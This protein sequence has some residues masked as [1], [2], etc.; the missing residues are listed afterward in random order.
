[1]PTCPKCH[2]ADSIFYHNTRQCVPCIKSNY[3]NGKARELVSKMERGKCMDCDML[4][5]P[6]THLAFEWDHREQCHKKFSVSQM[7]T[8]ANKTFHEE[9]AKCDL[10]CV[11][12]HRL[13]SIRRL[14][15]GETLFKT[16]RGRPRKSHPDQVS[17]SNVDLHTPAPP[18]LGAESV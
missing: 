2:V 16:P 12:H 15:T 17:S 11:L 8:C 1:M 10:V 7:A 18:L 13:R 3:R 14:N 4:V 6:E 5:T 9:I